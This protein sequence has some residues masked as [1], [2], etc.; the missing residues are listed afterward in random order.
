VSAPLAVTMLVEPR[1]LYAQGRICGTRLAFLDALPQ[2]PAPP[3]VRTSG[4]TGAAELPDRCLHFLAALG[5]LSRGLGDVLQQRPG[6]AADPDGGGLDVL[7][8]VMDRRTPMTAI[9]DLSGMRVRRTSSAR[10][11]GVW[12][13]RPFAAPAPSHFTSV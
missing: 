7:S 4:V 2:L 3:P 11:T 10:A 13:R 8:P 6:R 1:V 9:S 5:V 12:C